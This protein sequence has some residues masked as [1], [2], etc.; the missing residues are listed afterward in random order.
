M[1]K[2][3]DSSCQDLETGKG[4]VPVMHVKRIVFVFLF[5]YHVTLC[6]QQVSQ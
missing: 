2:D 4:K 3:V 1:E 6:N 5:F